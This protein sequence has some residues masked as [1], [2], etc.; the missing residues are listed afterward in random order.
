[1]KTSLKQLLIVQILMLLVIV[2]DFFYGNLF[3]SN[4]GLIFLIISFIVLYSIFKINIKNDY[5]YKQL[6][7]LIIMC[8][9][10]YF[11]LIYV[12]GLFTGF[13]KTIYKFGF[14]NLIYNIIPAAIYI[15]VMEFMRSIFIDKSSNNKIIIIISCLIFV[16]YD[17]SSMYY[18]YN[19]NV[20][21]ELYEFIGM[22]LL[23]SIARNIFLSIFCYRSNAINCIIYRLITE[24]Y[25]YIVPIVPN[26]GPYINSVLQ[27]TLPLIL[28]LF[29]IKPPMKI[30]QAPKKNKYSKI[31][32]LC[33][34]G[35][36]LVIILLNSGF[37]KYQMFVI[38]SNSMNKYIYRGDVIITRKTNSK[39]IKQIKKGD[40]LVFRYNN[41]IISH[42]VYKIIKKDSRIYFKTKGD[43]NDQPDNNIVKEKD[44]IGTVSF[45]IKYIGLPSIWLRETIG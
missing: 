16:L 6:L 12:A 38:G 8:L 9:M 30:L 42:R 14:S 33:V 20:S 18:L 1:M 24:I 41:K 2:I 25:I 28:G 4:F 45:R 3:E 13:A 26:F 17:V 40:I 37:V 11:I 27:I 43:N 44:V 29:I 39:E 23:T 10:F 15:V 35:I 32:S 31:L 21:D 5:K 36:L 22:V 19:F 7:K 34:T